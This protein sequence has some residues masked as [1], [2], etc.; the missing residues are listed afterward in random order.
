K[1]VYTMEGAP[2][3]AAVAQQTFQQLQLKNIRLIQGDFDYQLPE[4]LK[5]LDSVDFVYIDGNHRKA[6]TLDYFHQLL[7]RIHDDSILIF[8]DIHWSA[9]MESAW[10]EICR[11]PQVTATSDLFFIGI[12]FFRKEFL[13]KQHY[14]IRY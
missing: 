13:V 7:E 10:S 3:I 11:H 14:T 12:V 4:L 5:E 8:D 6:P 9:E 2:A 1:P